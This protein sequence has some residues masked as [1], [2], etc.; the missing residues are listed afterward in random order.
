MN[1]I[2]RIFAVS[3]SLG[4]ISFASESD[5]ETSRSV[6]PGLVVEDVG[7]TKLGAAAGIHEGDIFISAEC[8]AVTVSLDYP[9]AYY[10]LER[11]KEKCGLTTTVRGFEG[12]TA[13]LWKLGHT[14]WGVSV[15][16][17]FVGKLG[18]EYTHALELD[19]R[20]Q[21]TEAAA[22]MRSIETDLRDS[23]LTLR[24]W[25]E[26]R[27]AFMFSES[28]HWHDADDAFA[29]AVALG[30]LPEPIKAQIEYEWAESFLDRSD[31]TN[32]EAHYRESLK[33]GQAAHDER[34]IA[35]CWSGLGTVALKRGDLSLAESYF[36]RLLPLVERLSPNSL[37]VGT[38]LNNLGS[39]A[40]RRGDFAG[41]ER[42]FLKDLA[43]TEHIAPYSMELATS[44]S[45]FAALLIAQQQ[46]GRAEAYG[47]KSLAIVQQIH[48]E[49]AEESI[50][51]NNLGYIARRSGNLEKAEAFYLKA[52]VIKERIAPNSN[53][54]A[55][56]LI[57]LAEVA[58][59]RGNLT[60][61]D[62]YY[63][64]AL[65][66]GEKVAPGG[67]VVADS[68]YGLGKV[69]RARGDRE[70]ALTFYEQ[71][72]EIKHQLVPG[73]LQYA[74]TAASLAQVLSELGNAER[75]AALYE[76]AIRALETQTGHLSGD[77]EL[78][79]KYRADHEN[80]YWDY[81]VTLVGQ[82]RTAEAF[83]VVERFRAHNLLET[84]IEAKVNL[85]NGVDPGLLAEERSVQFQLAAAID[86]RARMGGRSAVEKEL[87]DIDKRIA[88][89]S[90]RRDSV[91]LQ[92]RTVYPAYAELKQPPTFECSDVQHL[93]LDRDTILLEY[94]LGDPQSYLF[95]V[96]SNDV[97][98]DTLPT[99]SVIETEATRVYRSLQDQHRST[100]DEPPA[101][102][103]DRLRTAHLR[104]RRSAAALSRMLLSPIGSS[105][106]GKRLLI[107]GDGALN[108]L[109]FGALFDPAELNHEGSPKPLVVDHEIVTSP[110]ASV[111][112]L[113]QRYSSA[114]HPGAK[115][116]AVFADPVF[117]KNDV[118][119]RAGVVNTV[120]TTVR[121]R[122]SSALALQM[123]LGSTKFANESSHQIRRLIFT[124]GE[125]KGIVEATGSKNV[126]MALDF[127]ASRRNALR[128][129]L[130]LYQI[131]HFATHGRL[132]SSHPERSG[133]ILSLV[134]QAGHPQNGFLSLMDV[135]NL[136]LNAELVVLSGCD[137]GL[138]KEIRGEGL[139]GLTRGFM[140]AGSSR[141]VASL[142]DV[143]DVATAQFMQQ[144]YILMLRHHMRPAAA[145][146]A[147]QVQMYNQAEW[148]S[149]YYWAAFQIQGLWR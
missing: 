146:R 8:R 112:A 73:T 106:K 31:W 147:A 35:D 124:R 4:V 131:V 144:F 122:G 145:L 39:V 47:L 40:Y 133:L 41:A 28:R 17:R 130:G 49:S 70:N 59:A 77:Q 113:L 85:D 79:S 135:Y 127:D 88:D 100:A 84:L 102:R 92:L 33:Q 20:S 117:D 45:N 11:R 137:T 60:S 54:T 62:Q 1:G 69:A 44:Y 66:L 94:V 9:F 121:S 12:T 26:L 18:A 97:T 14:D 89:L 109:P 99:R 63:R 46:L 37:K 98:V 2:L 104:Y 27:I 107:V 139:I 90:D 132:D 36:R 76:E 78:R 74:E 48:P 24:A 128:A 83:K 51:L 138:G 71:A 65:I 129:G 58:L 23:E 56:T 22:V 32:A 86:Q 81:I 25:I 19:A 143:D 38:N 61:A 6:L 29:Q 42:F 119:V 95:V 43:I 105:I 96:S 68:V 16:P 114:R 125:A 82:G 10:D 134:D 149:P 87:R 75:A 53:S 50:C 101:R 115:T 140:Y 141:V 21:L 7:K 110:S 108:Y 67:L 13:K 52:L 148:S 64:R 55:Y 116:L 120:P 123:S 93:L 126:L 3:L 80:Y 111:L 5:D 142:W 72:L 103:D 118:R 91:E 57:G 30:Q 136:R 15:R 34:R